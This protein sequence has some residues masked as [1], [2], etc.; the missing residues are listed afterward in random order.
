MKYK[1]KSTQQN[2]NYQAIRYKQE[3]E[4]FQELFIELIFTHLNQI[5]HYHQDKHT[6]N[7]REFLN[8]YK[9]KK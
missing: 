5:E 3:L 1:Q 4:G 9:N 7:L 6:K 8:N 2:T